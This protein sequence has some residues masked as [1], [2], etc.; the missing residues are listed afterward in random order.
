MEN[1]LNNIDENNERLLEPQLQGL[2]LK[3]KL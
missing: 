1:Q 3:I 2:T